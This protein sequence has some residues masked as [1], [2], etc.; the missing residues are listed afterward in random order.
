MLKL[1]EVLL[2]VLK[3]NAIPVGIPPAGA[4]LDG[5]GSTGAPSMGLGHASTAAFV[6][7]IYQKS[8]PLC[9]LI[10]YALL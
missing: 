7:K 3:Q 4:P 6:S 2:R 9:I 1:S 5:N 10:W 8:Q